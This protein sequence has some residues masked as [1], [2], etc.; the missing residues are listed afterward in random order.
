VD[1]LASVG[2]ELG[3]SGS[4]DALSRERSHQAAD[5]ENE[6]LKAAERDAL[7][8]ECENLKS[9]RTKG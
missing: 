8:I 1:G 4:Q 3:L 6:K 2:S 9:Y 7:K 5:I